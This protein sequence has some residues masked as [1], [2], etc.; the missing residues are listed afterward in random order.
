MA[1][2][3]SEKVRTPWVAVSSAISSARSPAATFEFSGSAITLAAASSMASL[4]STSTI[5]VTLSPRELI[6]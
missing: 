1:A 3:D 2:T 5:C 4:R 6:S